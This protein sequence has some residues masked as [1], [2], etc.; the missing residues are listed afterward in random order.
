MV[1][2]DVPGF[3][4]REPAT[5]FVELAAADIIKIAIASHAAI[6]VQASKNGRKGWVLIPKSD[7]ALL[8]RHTHVP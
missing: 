6:V 5:A 7:V 2:S 8:G 4:Q 3:I 1:L